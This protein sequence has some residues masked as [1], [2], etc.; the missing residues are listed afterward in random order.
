MSGVIWDE[1]VEEVVLL[2]EAWK[3]D[4]KYVATSSNVVWSDDEKLLENE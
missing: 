3:M 2:E 1:M 4:W